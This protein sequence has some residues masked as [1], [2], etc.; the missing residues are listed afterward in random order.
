MPLRKYSE[1]INEE[2]TDFSILP[3]HIND[4]SKESEMAIG[5]LKSTIDH[6]SELINIIANINDLPAWVQA[7]LT[8]STDYIETVHSYINS[9]YGLKDLNPK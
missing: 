6:A 8:K 4:L 9:K 3:K 5:Q 7:K 2:I 1:Y